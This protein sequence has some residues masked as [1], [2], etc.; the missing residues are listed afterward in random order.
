MGNVLE[1]PL[2]KRAP[3]RA[4]LANDVDVLEL[5]HS[6]PQFTDPD[7]L[8]FSLTNFASPASVRNLRA[9]GPHRSVGRTCSKAGADVEPARHG[10]RRTIGP[11]GAALSARKT[12]P[13]RCDAPDIHGSRTRMMSNE[14]GSL[15]R[16]SHPYE[17]MR[18]SSEHG[19]IKLST[20]RMHAGRGCDGLCS[21]AQSRILDSRKRTPIRCAIATRN[22]GDHSGSKVWASDRRCDR[23][24]AAYQS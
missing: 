16:H 22:Q 15:N 14:P 2:E 13:I 10:H 5:V 11:R 12:D 24:P 23:R 18:S 20:H 21:F 17:C 3:S 8:S 6:S 4:C 7:F 1:Q 19:R 9:N